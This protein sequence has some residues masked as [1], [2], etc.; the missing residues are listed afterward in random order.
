[1]SDRPLNEVTEYCE[2]CAAETPHTVSLEIVEESP[3]ADHPEMSNEP[4]RTTECEHCGAAE[5]TRL[6]SQ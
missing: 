6:N 2:R 1:M 4:Y 3:H 5:T